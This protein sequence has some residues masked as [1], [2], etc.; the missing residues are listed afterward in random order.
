MCRVWVRVSVRVIV[1]CYGRGKT[2]V[3]VII[4]VRVGLVFIWLLLG[5]GLRL[6]S[7]LRKTQNY[8]VE[9]LL[10]IIEITILLIT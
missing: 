9:K 5:L 2:G 4:R 7:T 6:G 3:R 8:I 10:I 1:R